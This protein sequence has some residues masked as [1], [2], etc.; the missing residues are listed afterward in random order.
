M[1]RTLSALPGMVPASPAHG[2]AADRHP[3]PPGPARTTH[4]QPRTADA[5]R[6][7]ARHAVIRHE[8][9][10]TP[11]VRRSRRSHFR[12][13]RQ[14]RER[15]R[16]SG[17]VVDPTTNR[18]FPPRR[19]TTL[20]CHGRGGRTVRR[21]GAQNRY[22]EA[23]RTAPISAIPVRTTRNPCPNRPRWALCRGGLGV[24][25]LWCCPVRLRSGSFDPFL[26]SGRRPQPGNP[27]ASR[28]ARDRAGGGPATPGLWSG[29][30][31]SGRCGGGSRSCPGCGP[32]ER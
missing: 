5:L 13:E 8:H 25:A 24:R 26:C 4:P 10:A 15:V 16:L 31:V 2:R 30:G 19:V 9:L 28:P 21:I 3:L 27:H 1:S 17:T 7:Q 6:L 14:H 32:G 22:V 29:P 11:I 12:T 18:P 23:S 20:R